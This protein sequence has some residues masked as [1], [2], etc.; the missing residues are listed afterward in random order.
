MGR[1]YSD[2]L[3]CHAIELKSC[4]RDL[5][6][7]REARVNEITYRAYSCIVTPTTYRYTT[8][9]YKEDVR[10][11][12][13]IVEFHN[14]CDQVALVYS[15]TIHL[16]PAELEFPLLAQPCRPIIWTNL[17]SAN[18]LFI[19]KTRERLLPTRSYLG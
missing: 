14:S 3:S 4:R 8:C 6:Q 11:K 7:P 2:T 15:T 18:S 9:N 12:C 17:S 16:L 13:C 1:L 10:T 5:H 19:K